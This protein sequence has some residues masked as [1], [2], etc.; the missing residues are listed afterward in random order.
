MSTSK[1]KKKQMNLLNDLTKLLRK[2]KMGEL[3]INIFTKLNQLLT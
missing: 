2:T 1:H 3:T